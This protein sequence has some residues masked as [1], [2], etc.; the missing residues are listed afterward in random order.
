VGPDDG[1]IFVPVKFS[2]PRYLNF[3]GIVTELIPDNP[4]EMLVIN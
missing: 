1:D 3:C 4:I 2:Y